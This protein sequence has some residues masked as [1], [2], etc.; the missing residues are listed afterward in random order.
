MKMI[1]RLES[2]THVTSAD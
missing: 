1:F 2:V